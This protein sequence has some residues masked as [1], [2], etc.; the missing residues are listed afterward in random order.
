MRIATL[1][2]AALLLLAACGQPLPADKAVYAGDWRARDMRIVIRKDGHVS[3][4]RREGSN[5]K[6]I[7]APIQRFEGDNFVVGVGPLT[8]TFVVSKPPWRDEALWKMTV[9]GVELIRRGGADDLRA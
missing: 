4:E 2:A 3:Y 8:T 9:D 5:S 1:F 7:N 6:S